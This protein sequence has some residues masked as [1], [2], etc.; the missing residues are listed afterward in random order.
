MIGQPGEIGVGE[1]DASEG[2]A[3]QNL[4]QPGR[5]TTRPAGPG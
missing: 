1:G 5:G 2:R 3:A 4:P